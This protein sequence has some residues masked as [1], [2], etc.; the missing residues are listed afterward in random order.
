MRL[1]V[2]RPEP[3]ASALARR[4]I[5]LGHEAYVAP[6]TRIEPL[7][8]SLPLPHLAETTLL[9]S[10]ANAFLPFQRIDIDQTHF[11][12]VAEFWCVGAKTAEAGC[13]LGLP[14]PTVLGTDA[15][16]L[17]HQITQTSPRAR[18]LYMA[19]LQRSPLLEDALKS[20]GIEFSVLETYDAPAIEQPFK[21]IKTD[22]VE[23]VLLMSPR[24]AEV[25]IQR[26]P[27]KNWP[28]VFCLSKQIA[29]SL[30]NKPKDVRIAR[31]PDMER[32]LSLLED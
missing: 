19:G 26:W 18:V 14:T 25:F 31:T 20:R 32:L 1:L 29:D 28:T 4:L 10:S 23:G 15:L 3:A 16:N 27:G 11:H 5:G 21:D 6:L 22:A 24:A 8:V 30:A 9:A 17:V 7:E 12:Q 13:K 2:T